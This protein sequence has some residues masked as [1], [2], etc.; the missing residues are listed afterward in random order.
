MPRN[1]VKV[2]PKGWIVIPKPLRERYGLKPGTEVALIEYG[3][4]LSLVPLPA[5]PIEAMRGLFKR[6]EG[7]PPLTEVL[8]AEHRREI[9]RDE[10]LP[11]PEEEHDA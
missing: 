11:R 6:P 1:L 5:D 3:G 9:A 4:A 8:L 10:A 2:S 7:A